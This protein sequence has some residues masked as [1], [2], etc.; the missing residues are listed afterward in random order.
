[1]SCQQAGFLF[2]RLQ[3]LQVGIVAFNSNTYKPW[4]FDFRKFWR[5]IVGLPLHIE[6]TLAWHKI[7]HAS[8]EQ[9]PH[10]TNIAQ[11]YK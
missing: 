4:D 11:I 8:H 3:I 10:F 5:S 6:G 9:A 1:M 7:L 2:H